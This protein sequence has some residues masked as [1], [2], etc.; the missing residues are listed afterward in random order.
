MNFLRYECLMISHIL[1]FYI[2]DSNNFA[3]KIDKTYQ[4]DSL[5]KVGND[6]RLI[7]YDFK[8]NKT[9]F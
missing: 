3:H 4:T 6:I 2:F 9:N 7:K 1:Q 8:M 5:F